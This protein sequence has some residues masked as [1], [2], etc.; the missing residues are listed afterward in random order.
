MRE[1]KVIYKTHLIMQIPLISAYRTVQYEDS[2]ACGKNPENVDSTQILSQV[3]C[4]T[5]RTY[6]NARARVT[7]AR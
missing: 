7:Y 4:L 1:R 5:C 3:D 2:I 6:I